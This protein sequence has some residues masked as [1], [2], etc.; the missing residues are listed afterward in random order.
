MLRLFLI[1]FHFASR[2]LFV[3]FVLL[4][5]RYWLLVLEPGVIAALIDET[6]WTT[7]KRTLNND[8]IESGY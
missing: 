5:K 7:N 2:H 6:N 8:K 4:P 1:L 3:F